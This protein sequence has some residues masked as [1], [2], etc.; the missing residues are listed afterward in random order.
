[1]SCVLSV[2]YPE[3]PLCASLKIHRADNAFKTDINY[4][5]TDKFST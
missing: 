5:D 2:C 4:K 1:M 3:N